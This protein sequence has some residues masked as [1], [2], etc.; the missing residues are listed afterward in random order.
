MNKHLRT[1][2]RTG[3]SFGAAMS[4]YFYLQRRQLIAAAIGVLTGV[5][6]GA[7][8]AYL[9]WRG[10]K[11]LLAR[12]FEVADMSPIQERQIMY[13]AG[14]NAAL[15]AAR[16]ALGAVRKMRDITVDA[17][18]G[19]IV[20]RTGMSWQSFGE[21]ICVRVNACPAGCI[22]DIRSE[23]RLSSTQGD[24]GKGVENV[25]AFSQALRNYAEDHG[26]VPT[27]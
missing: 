16:S 22:V 8:M 10:E 26:C 19:K 27:A 3:V 9:Q 4:V 13:P 14:M 21:N 12:G 7:W 20:A 25:E 15:E 11:R 24:S 18:K 23:P 5:P 2:M 1:F 6:F 17:E